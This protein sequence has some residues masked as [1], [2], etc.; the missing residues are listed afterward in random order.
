MNVFCD[1]VV[2][3]PLIPPLEKRVVE[4]LKTAMIYMFFTGVVYV[5]FE[6]TFNVCV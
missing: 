5:N 6:C 3:L 4:I 1:K 2:C